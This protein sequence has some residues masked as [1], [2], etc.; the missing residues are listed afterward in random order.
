[1][2]PTQLRLLAYLNGCKLKVDEFV[3]NAI[4]LFY[5]AYANSHTNGKKC[6][7]DD[8]IQ[9]WWVM[10]KARE[11]Y[12]LSKHEIDSFVKNEMKKDGPQCAFLVN[13]TEAQKRG[14]TL[15]QLLGEARSQ[16]AKF[17]WKKRIEVLVPYIDNGYTNQQLADKL[18]EIRGEEFDKKTVGKYVKAYR[19]YRKLNVKNFGKVHVNPDGESGNG[20]KNAVFDD[21]FRSDLIRFDNFSDSDTPT[22][23]ATTPPVLTLSSDIHTSPSSIMGGISSTTS[24]IAVANIAR[25]ADVEL[26]QEQFNS[27]YDD[28]LP[29]KENKKRI[30]EKL[31]IKGRTYYNYKNKRSK[32]H[33]LH[34]GTV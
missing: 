30:E 1:M 13:R 32:A 25:L 24:Q 14:M 15:I 20:R 23:T 18:K 7:G 2:F 31:G 16:Y 5:L 4:Y 34:K 26:R 33:R 22:A 3:Y 21:L 11:V 6:F 8:F 27:L 17:Q 9:P 28:S 10:E 19:E 29:D 12:Q